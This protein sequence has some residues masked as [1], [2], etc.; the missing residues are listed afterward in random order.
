MSKDFLRFMRDRVSKNQ[1]VEP[2]PSKAEWHEIL[3]AASR[4]ADHGGLKP[5]RFQVYSGEG[6]EQVGQAYWLH[7]K[8]EVPELSD[9]KAVTFIKKAFRAPAIVLVYADLV[10]HPKVPQF[11]QLMA[12]SAAAQQVLL[13]L[14]ALG[15][16]GMWRTGPAVFTDTAKDLFGLEPN[17]HVV[18]LIYAGTASHI[19]PRV[20][21]TGVTER[22]TFID[23]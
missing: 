3:D 7:A 10:D 20:E 17:Q 23:Q 5:W 13:G 22:V 14:D 4:A 9:D 2:A 21:D 12:A 11:E 18:G 19:P 8:A 15:Y 6:R 1:L 16:G